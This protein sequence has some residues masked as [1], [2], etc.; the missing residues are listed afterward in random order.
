MSQLA[1]LHALA[2]DSPYQ[3][4][5]PLMVNLPEG[6]VAIGADLSAP[7]L[8]SAYF[9]GIF[10][11]FGEDAPIAWY[12]PDPRCVLYPKDFAP[13]KSLIATA[14][15]HTQKSHTPYTITLNRAFD[16]VIHACSLPRVFGGE[17]VLQTW[18]TDSMK[19]A[20]K[21]L[22]ALG[23][24]HSIEVWAHD[25]N[26]P[27]LIGGLYG[28]KLGG[29]FCGESMFYRRSDASKLAFWALNRLCLASQVQLIDC[30]L[31]NAHLL[32]LGA[33]TV[34]KHSF[35]HHLKQLTTVNYTNVNW[36]QMHFEQSIDWLLTDPNAPA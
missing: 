15:R 4:P 17:Q 35:I 31:P 27:T 36:C 30:Q 24:A 11:W 21:K 1:D 18:I 34:S 5:D 12:S 28:I 32:S 19:D 23:A 2:A 9:A 14:K 13:T 33:R 8:L 26:T 3:L 7:V 10:P 29:V 22:H 20:Y 6:I 25:C 16:E